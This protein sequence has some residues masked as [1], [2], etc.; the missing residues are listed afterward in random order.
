MRL[1]AMTV[2]LSLCLI[3]TS[4]IIL[5][6]SKIESVYPNA[7]TFLTGSSSDFMRGDA[8]L[9]IRKE[10]V[11]V[12]T[13]KVSYTRSGYVYCDITESFLGRTPWHGD[14]VIKADAELIKIARAVSAREQDMDGASHYHSPSEYNQTAPAAANIRNSYSYV[15][16]VPVASMEY[17][18]A[19]PGELS[20][21]T[22]DD[23]RGLVSLQA[24][25][26]P[27]DRLLREYAETTGIEIFVEPS[28]LP[29][30]DRSIVTFSFDRE[31]V[32]AGLSMVLKKFMLMYF[33]QNNEF[34]IISEHAESHEDYLA[35]HEY[36]IEK[37]KLNFADA[38][39]VRDLIISMDLHPAPEVVKAYVGPIHPGAGQ[40]LFTGEMIDYDSSRVLPNEQIVTAKK[41]ILLIKAT[42]ETMKEIHRIVELI[43]AA[44]KQVMIKALLIEVDRS[45][46]D[47]VGAD[48]ALFPSFGRYGGSIFNGSMGDDGKLMVGVATE[49]IMKESYDEFITLLHANLLRRKA[50]IINNPTIA[51]IDGQPALIQVGKE[52]PLRQTDTTVN[53]G[54]MFSSSEI[55][56]RR[57]GMSLYVL[58]RIHDSDG[59]ND[60]SLLLHPVVSQL[61]SEFM[62]QY[63]DTQRGGL[64]GAFDMILGTSRAS[65]TESDGGS[66]P[67]IIVRET[68]SIV[69]VGN[70]EEIIIGGLIRKENKTKVKKVPLLGDLPLVG[71]FFRHQQDYIDE[72]E[73]VI[74]LVPYL[75]DELKSDERV[76]APAFDLLYE[77]YDRINEKK[78]YEERERLRER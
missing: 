65:K 56:Y 35:K 60:I 25:E 57:V 78:M 43:D 64:L 74:I 38:E 45:N 14:S 52:I 10:N 19:S 13:G 77:D 11:Y 4:Q 46:K 40:S 41:D 50:K 44:P 24:R 21:F 63:K 12:A 18:N 61:E 33:K 54:T 69:R 31:S 34:H 20:I 7:F 76:K 75:L 72:Q 51:T 39:T 28:A 62:D 22:A 2:F 58:P 73:L 59:R 68:N 36:V 27:L 23:N 66:Y 70:G 67:N 53:E 6:E 8:V 49:K 9:V 30:I 26:V 55:N 47:D 42:E 29:Q 5:A 37:I 48:L 15:N 1:R 71:N 32:E 17:R 16:S 3:L